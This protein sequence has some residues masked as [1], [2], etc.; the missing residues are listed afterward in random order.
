[1][2]NLAFPACSKDLLQDALEILPNDLDTKMTDALKTLEPDQAAAVLA[3]I[4]Q[5]ASIT[6]QQI[7]KSRLTLPSFSS[8]KWAEVAPQLDLPDKVDDLLLESFS[9]PSCMLPLSMHRAMFKDGWRAM[10]VYREKTQQDREAARIKLLEPWLVPIIALFEGRVVDLPESAMVP[11]IYSS[12]GAVEHEIIVVG[13]ALFFVVEMKL[14][15]DKDCTAQL[16]LELLSA[17]EANKK[18]KYTGLR[19]YGLLTDLTLFHF[20]SFDPIERS[21]YK[22]DVLFA[23]VIRELFCGDMIPVANKIFSVLMLGYLESLEATVALSKA[24]GQ[25]G[26]CSSDKGSSPI[27]QMADK[28][29]ILASS[30]GAKQS[31]GASSHVRPSLTA[32]ENGLALAKQAYDDLQKCALAESIDKFEENAI[33][34]LDTLSKSVSCLPRYSLYSGPSDTPITPAGL[35]AMAD[36]SVKI[37]HVDKLA[38]TRP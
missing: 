6:D 22:D 13:R 3:Y 15:L 36:K 33:N 23:N 16:F 24:R 30:S 7:K 38:K 35:D 11:T 4:A 12:G 25:S 19:V 9:P 18:L 8:A 32:W 1:M 27:H 31:K 5:Q 21:F 37:W 20:Y 28:P 17:A 26:M 29:S 34:A 14:L 10:D 2:P